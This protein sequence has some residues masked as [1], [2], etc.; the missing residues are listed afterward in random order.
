MHAV[1]LSLA[2]ALASAVAEREEQRASPPPS[3]RTDAAT[4][5]TPTPRES[6]PTRPAENHSLTGTPLGA[7]LSTVATNFVTLQALSI[8][9]NG[10]SLVASGVQCVC[11]PVGSMAQLLVLALELAAPGVAALAAWEMNGRVVRWRSPWLWMLLTQYVLSVLTGAVVAAVMAGG[12]V[13][14]QLVLLAAFYGV[15]A[16]WLFSFAWLYNPVMPF[17][18]LGPALA[19]AAGW[20]FLIVGITW[21]AASALSI[22][23]SVLNSA[24]LVGVVLYSGRPMVPGETH[25]MG[26]MTD[27]P[28]PPGDVEENA[29]PRPG[30]HAD[31]R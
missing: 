15:M 19:G 26:D 11:P 22:V 14:A 9:T 12:M 21:L 3:A 7:A 17:A 27:L 29:A 13:L 2:M 31:D 6:A 23:G 18:L 30:S 4:K 8:L 28:D 24:A 10:L 16:T 5:A 1:V 20:A 25:S